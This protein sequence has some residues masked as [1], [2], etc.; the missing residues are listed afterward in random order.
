MNS[1]SDKDHIVTTLRYF[2]GASILQ[3]ASLL[4]I[5]P[6]TVKSRLYHA[7]QIMRKEILKM[8]NQ[9]QQRYE[10]IPED[11]RNV[12]VGMRGE[13]G[14][15]KIFTG[16]F[17]GWSVGGES[18]APNTTPEFWEIVGEDGLVG[19][20]YEDGA[21][22]TYGDPSWKDIEFS[23]VMTPLKGGNAQLVF[24]VD[25]AS[26]RFYTF[27]MLMGW[28][29]AGV[30]RVEQDES[31]NLNTTKLSVVNYP[32]EHGHDYAVTVA[33]R[34]HSITTYIDGALVNQVTDD[35]WLTGQV[36]LNIWQSKTLY[37]DIRIR[38]LH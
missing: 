2:S 24:R 14:W 21:R 13:I 23:V 38:V 33:A 26:N 12:I 34:D 22:L 18:I 8:A 17:A 20:E 29:S 1:L 7:R 3:I 36:G 9:T 37:R 28:Q 4:D 25:Q 31:G 11:F 32:F 15:Q 6:G 30:H 5:P 10:H 16:D 35:S 27:D 19:E